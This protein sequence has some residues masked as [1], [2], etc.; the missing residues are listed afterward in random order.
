MFWSEPEP[1]ALVGRLIELRHARNQGR[2]LDLATV[3]YMPRLYFDRPPGAGFGW[4]NGLLYS[5]HQL[6]LLP[7]L[8]R[9]L[10]RSRIRIRAGRR[11]VTLPTAPAPFVQSLDRYRRIVLVATAIEARYL[12]TL[13]PEWVHLRGVEADEW[14]RYREGF[15]PS[16][17]SVTLGCSAEQIR[18]DAEHLLSK[19]HAIDPVGEAWGRLIRRSPPDSWNGLKNMARSAMDLRETAELLLCFYD[20]LA[21]RGTADPLPTSEL[22]PGMGWHPLL[23]RLSYKRQTLDQDLMGLGISPHPRVVLAI[24]GETEQLHF[25][26]VWST[27]GLPDAPELLRTIKLGGVDNDPVKVGVLAAAPLIARRDESKQFWWVVKP[28]TCFI[29]AIDPEGKYYGTPEKVAN[30]KLN[31][32]SEVRAVVAAQGA[33]LLNDELDALVEIHT[34]SDSCYEFAHFSDDELADGIMAVHTTINDLTRD[35]LIATLTKTRRRCKDIKEVW[36]QW[37]Y[38]VSKPELARALW[39]SL[40]RK[41]ESAKAGETAPMPDV[42]ELVYRAYLK[43]QNWRYRTFVL[44]AEPPEPSSS[45]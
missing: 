5:H 43:A 4:W 19:A 24:E 8:R 34:W 15:D 10:D 35:Q 30:T 39:P 6:V 22:N 14:R 32:L 7:E 33:T 27:L 21:K 13:D 9:I 17:M 44:S 31:I 40:E 23:E 38:S 16:A 37:S 1:R 20:D 25:P 18:Q 28:P 29:I 36:S 26:R 3:P 12:P 41:I 42:A 11:Y 2:L 45:S